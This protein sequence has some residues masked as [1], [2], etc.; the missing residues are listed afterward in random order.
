VRRERTP[1]VGPEPR[2][3]EPGHQPPLRWYHRPR[4]YATDRTASGTISYV[5][6]SGYA[7]AFAASALLAGGTGL[8]TQVART[9]TPASPR[10]PLDRRE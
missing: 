2:L 3:S 6:G 4:R 8:V 5:G 7:A 10:L 1:S 9:L